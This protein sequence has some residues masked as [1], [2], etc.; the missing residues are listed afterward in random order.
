MFQLSWYV[1]LKAT[2]SATHAE[3]LQLGVRQRG[4]RAGLRLVHHLAPEVRPALHGPQRGDGHDDVQ[5]DARRPQQLAH[6]TRGLPLVLEDREAAAEHLLSRGRRE[7]VDPA[8]LRVGD[9]GGAG[10]QNFEVPSHRA[11]QV[12]AVRDVLEDAA[13]LARDP[14]RDRLLCAVAERVREDADA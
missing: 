13:V 6:L 8:R 9:L 2:A 10:G 5:V 12:A 7:V 1:R 14:L 11:G 4:R 3:T